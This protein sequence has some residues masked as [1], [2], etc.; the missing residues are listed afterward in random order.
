[1]KQ[2]FIC[3]ISIFILAIGCDDS[4][5]LKGTGD[6]ITEVREI[7]D[8]IDIIS[9]FDNLSLDIYIDSLNYIEIS[10]GENV[11]EFV[12]TEIIRNTLVLKN[13]NKC[14]FLRDFDQ[15]ISIGLHITPF[16]TIEY[17]G[18]RNITMHDTLR[19]DNFRFTST[20][21]AGS[22]KILLNC[23]GTSLVQ[24]I[25]GFADV[26]LFGKSLHTG[27]FNDGSGWIYGKAFTNQSAY[28]RNRSTGDC[29]VRA[30]STLKCVLNGIGN[31]Q[32]VGDPILIIENNGKGAVF[33]TK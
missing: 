33:Q 32:Y 4:P 3:T 18:S 24:C 25:N 31:I 19:V 22:I 20:E 11:I 21:G 12:E 2:L 13:N 1:M 27:F 15:D 6:N 29:I 14:G 10:A 8:G 17:S 16:N 9:L 5:C 28:V 26:T 30:D 7:P 23:S